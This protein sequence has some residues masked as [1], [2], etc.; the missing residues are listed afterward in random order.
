[1]Q[2]EQFN[3]FV[4]VASAEHVLFYYNGALSQN[5]VA[6]IGDIL[7]QRLQEQGT[8]GVTSRKVFSTFIEMAQNILHYSTDPSA[9]SDAAKAGALA[10]SF[11]D[12]RFAVMCGNLV[13]GKSVQRVREKLEAVR[14]MSP[15][16][17]KDA[18]RKQLRE[19]TDDT[20]KGAGL[21]FLTMARD[22]S[23][24]VEFTFSALPNDASDN[25]FLFL[26]AVI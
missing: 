8:S 4:A 12:G 7:K 13:T 23:A 24:P 19:E 21:G 1:M 18:Y 25:Q 3:H 10:V 14:S 15:E 2:L 5:A 17:I 22:A 6:S 26:R 9:T 16:E 11:N 20:S